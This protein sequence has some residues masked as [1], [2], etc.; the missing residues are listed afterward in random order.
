MNSEFRFIFGK[1]GARV[2]WIKT[3]FSLSSVFGKFDC[4]T[5]GAFLVTLECPI[6]KTNATFSKLFYYIFYVE[7]GNTSIW[8]DIETVAAQKIWF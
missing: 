7:M 1:L 4:Q 2:A 3:C 8:C 5:S 6:I